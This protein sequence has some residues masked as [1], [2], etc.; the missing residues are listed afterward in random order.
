MEHRD[1]ARHLNQALKSHGILNNMVRE[2]KVDEKAAA[3]VIT[4]GR[5]TSGK[6][7]PKTSDLSV[8]FP[9]VTAAE[10]ARQVLKFGV[11]DVVPAN[12]GPV[13]QTGQRTYAAPAMRHD[14][15]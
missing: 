12:D 10:T 9:S 7:D 15:V 6:L 11:P 5:V 8:V 2:S 3:L 13:V 14:V 1:I 4:W